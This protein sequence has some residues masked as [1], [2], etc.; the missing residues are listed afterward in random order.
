VREALEERVRTS[1]KA[2]ASGLGEVVR[3]ASRRREERR[4]MRLRDPHKHEAFEEEGLG[5]IVANWWGAVMAKGPAIFGR[6]TEARDGGGNS[7]IEVE[8]G[9]QTSAEATTKGVI[10]TNTT[11]TTTNATDQ[12][13]STPA[14][15]YDKPTGSMQIVDLTMEAS[16]TPL[17]PLPQ[18]NVEEEETIVAIGAGA[19]LFPGKAGPYG[20][21]NGDEERLASGSSGDVVHDIYNGTKKAVNGVVEGVQMGKGVVEG[22]E[23]RGQERA[24]KGPENGP[25]GSRTWRSDAFNFK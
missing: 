6:S 7:D 22:A 24:K 17:L 21:S 20:G 9:T 23:E 5:E 13:H 11:T 14:V 4:V 16:G 2:L 8:V 25:G 10:F 1:V 3:D 12:R 19:Q 18:Q 15:V